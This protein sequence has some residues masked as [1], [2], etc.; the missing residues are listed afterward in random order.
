[1]SKHYIIGIDGGSQSTKVVIFDLQGN[2]VCEGKEKLRPLYRP[3]PGVAEHPDDDLWNTL[4][5][6]SRRAM[7]E[8]EGDPADILGVG[9]CTIR[10]CRADLKADGSLAAP[11]M[12][13]MDLRLSKPYEHVNPEVRYVTTSSGYIGHR[14]TGE[15]TDTTSNYEGPW[16][17]DKDR[18]DWSDDPAVLSEYNL[19]RS[20]LF[21]LVPPGGVL[22]YITEDAASQTCLPAGLPVAAT[23]NDKAVEALGAGLLSGNRALVSLGTYIGG[24][25]YGE[26][27]IKNADTFFSNMASVPYRFLYE[28][29]GIRKGM[30]TVS[31]FRELFGNSLEHEASAL[32]S[33]PEELLNSEGSRVPA[34]SDG[35]M[36]VLDWLAPPDKPFK[37]GMMI[38]FD[39]RHGRGHMY[40]SILEGIALTMKTH[41]EAMCSE[42]GKQPESVIISGGGSNSGLFMQIFADAFGLPAERTE[43]NEAASI[44]SAI[45]AA[46][47]VG[48]YEDFQSAVTHMVRPRD[49]FSPLA[50]HTHLYERM[51]SEVYQKITQY[52]D[53]LLKRSYPLFNS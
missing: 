46:V 42:L 7:E 40:R 18:W 22:G 17:I 11:V 34:G 38:G 49:V 53:E 3:S 5:I 2:I 19:P 32:G 44:G 48:A 16:P 28:S 37:K 29:G 10:C 13:W 8:F 39:G 52:S 26:S 51:N 6:A 30:W 25:T 41:V 36:T 31:W 27:N 4:V 14:L 21:D 23:A 24:M 43:V 1:M 15:C 20:M 12:S 50:E 45:C 35:L 9:L 33:S 47:C